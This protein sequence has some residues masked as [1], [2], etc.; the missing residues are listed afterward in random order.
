MANVKVV[1]RYHSF[2]DSKSEKWEG[3]KT[4]FLLRDAVQ[5]FGA[6]FAVE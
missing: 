5:F 3:G 2:I 6:K 1:L 4:H